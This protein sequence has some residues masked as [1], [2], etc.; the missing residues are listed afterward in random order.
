MRLEKAGRTVSLVQDELKT[1]LE[2]PIVIAPAVVSWRRYANSGTAAYLARTYSG[3]PTSGALLLP[4]SPT[5]VDIISGKNRSDVDA[6]VLA[7]VAHVAAARVALC[8]VVTGVKGTRL[9]GGWKTS[10]EVAET[11]KCALRANLPLAPGYVGPFVLA[12]AANNSLQ[13]LVMR[14]ASIDPVAWHNMLCD[15]AGPPAHAPLPS[16]APEDTDETAAAT[17]QDRTNER[18]SGEVSESSRT[19]TGHSQESTGMLEAKDLASS[20]F[21]HA[22]LALADV[23]AGT[24]FCGAPRTDSIRRVTAEIE[25][26]G[27]TGRLVAHSVGTSSDLPA[28]ALAY[29]A[30]L[31]EVRKSRTA[32]DRAFLNLA[33]PAALFLYDL[34]ETTGTAVSVPDTR[35]F[36]AEL[37]AAWSRA[38]EP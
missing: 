7:W 34:L 14:V 29:M 16:S 13:A 30:I 35:L 4:F 25:S 18:H 8:S 15:V 2:S 33:A 26:G 24:A 17:F 22:L 12:V 32:A 6:S 23:G 28:A 20:A 3:V 11:F 27:L 5:E 38:G 31:S 1:L 37:D 10:R 21:D 19:E 36:L 9:P